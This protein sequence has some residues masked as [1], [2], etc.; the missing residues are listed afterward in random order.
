MTVKGVIFDKDGTLFDF[1]ATWGVWTG[2]AIR[3]IAGDDVDMAT[4]LNTVWGYDPIGQVLLRESIV[5]A[6]TPIEIWEVASPV[7]GLTPQQMISR[8]TLDAAD[9]PQAAIPSGVDALVELKRRGLYLGVMT[10]DG[11][12]AAISHLSREGI[13]DLFDPVVG[14]DSGHGAKPTPDPLN[15]IAQHWGLSP[16]TIAMVG[17][18]LHDLH[19][20]RSAGMKTVAVLTGVATAD[21]L[22]PFADV[23]LDSIV[24]L[25]EWIL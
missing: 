25:P 20:G 9:A 14:S 1:Q 2:Q 15:F 22:A 5:I 3:D 6:A 11:E 12:N 23:V 16:D 8:M 19:A 17:D 4:R 13:L 24:N 21:D 10:N 7:T 18:S